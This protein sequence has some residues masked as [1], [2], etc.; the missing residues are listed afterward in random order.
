MEN[1]NSEFLGIIQR[2]NGDLSSNELI[3]TNLTEA[4]LKFLAEIIDA[5]DPKDYTDH[6]ERI[7]EIVLFAGTGEKEFGE[8]DLQCIFTLNELRK[9]F[10][11]LQEK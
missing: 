11:T 7:L 5:A 3:S 9:Y 2:H 4:Q 6:L 1:K 8:H 10:R